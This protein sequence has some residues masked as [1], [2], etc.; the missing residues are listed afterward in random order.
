M[1]GD[2]T[3]LYIRT[4]SFWEHLSD[5]EKDHVNAGTHPTHFE[6]SAQLHRDPGDCLG[7]LLVKTG[8]LRV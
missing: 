3:D 2:A 5:R 6:R 4:F 1:L 7:I 8:Q